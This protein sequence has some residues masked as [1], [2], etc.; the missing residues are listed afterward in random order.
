MSK[1]VLDRISTLSPKSQ[2][3]YAY[4]GKEQIILPDTLN[5]GSSPSKT[6]IEVPPL[7]PSYVNKDYVIYGYVLYDEDIDGYYSTDNGY[8]ETGYVT[9]TKI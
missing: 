5:Y 3:N 9:P 8:S 1:S 4:Y 7:D 2:G 6:P